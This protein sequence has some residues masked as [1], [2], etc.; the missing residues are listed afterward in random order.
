MYNAC[1]VNT[2]AYSRR[3]SECL[4]IIKGMYQNNRKCKLWWWKHLDLSQ[5]SLML[6]S[7][8][9]PFKNKWTSLK[10]HMATFPI[11]SP[12]GF[13]SLSWQI[14][15]DGVCFFAV[16]FFCSIW[17]LSLTFCGCLNILCL[18]VTK[19]FLTLLAVQKGS[20]A[21]FKETISSSTVS[22]AQG[23]GI[24]H[25]INLKGFIHKTDQKK[26][27]ASADV[28]MHVEHEIHTIIHFTAL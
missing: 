24:I 1:F 18:F 17:F 3:Y 8:R 13:W 9:Y 4:P 6:S 16:Y 11:I 28:L 23:Q 26:I 25:S 20:S 22:L 14:C 27:L 7:D 10:A 2:V 21:S 5:I 12:G 19:W 15:L